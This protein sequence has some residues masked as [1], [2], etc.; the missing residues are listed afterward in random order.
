VAPA[1][2]PARPTALVVVVIELE[3]SAFANFALSTLSTGVRIEVVAIV[4]LLSI[5]TVGLG[6]FGATVN[7]C[8]DTFSSTGL[9]PINT[10][11]DKAMT[12]NTLVNVM[13]VIK[14]SI[15]KSC[16]RNILEILFHL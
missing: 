6:D 4:E 5:V 13:L 9:A 7:S 1:A 11:N 14:D 2:G 8:D 16:S 3:L 15:K 12:A 10:P